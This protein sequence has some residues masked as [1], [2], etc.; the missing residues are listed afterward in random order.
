MWTLDQPDAHVIYR[1]WNHPIED[2]TPGFILRVKHK[3]LVHLV[4]NQRRRMQRL[5]YKFSKFVHIPTPQHDIPDLAVECIDLFKQAGLLTDNIGEDLFHQI[6]IRHAWWDFDDR[7]RQ[8][9][10]SR[11]DTFRQFV[12]VAFG[13]D[14]HAADTLLGKYGQ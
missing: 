10:G 6:T 9:I 5:A 12:D 3:A 8:F 1:C 13:F 7:K 4:G 14:A 11:D 2:G